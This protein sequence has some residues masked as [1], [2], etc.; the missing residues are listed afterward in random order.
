MFKKIKDI[1]IKHESKKLEQKKRYS[2]YLPSSKVIYIKS[3]FN[4]YLLKEL[5]K[6]ISDTYFNNYSYEID[7]VEKNRTKHLSL[8]KKNDVINIINDL[9][10]KRS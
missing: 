5:N 1:L 7:I 4:I 6:Y 9:K 3:D 2:V 10:N 8:S